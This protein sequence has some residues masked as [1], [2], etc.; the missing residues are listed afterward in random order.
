MKYLVYSRDP[1][2]YRTELA[3]FRSLSDAKEYAY[4]QAKRHGSFFDYFISW[5]NQHGDVSETK[6]ISVK[7]PYNASKKLEVVE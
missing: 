4:D 7:T 1:F 5:E 3:I 2:D 6:T